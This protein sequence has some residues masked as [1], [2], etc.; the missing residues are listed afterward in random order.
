MKRWSGA[1]AV[2][3]R[4][5]VIRDWSVGRVAEVAQSVKVGNSGGQDGVVGGGGEASSAEQGVVVGAG[6]PGLLPAVRQKF[7][8]DVLLAE[9][10]QSGARLVRTKGHMRYCQRY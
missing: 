4:A 5:W 6:N 3:S 10:G 7:H 2:G 9:G 8:L 1:V